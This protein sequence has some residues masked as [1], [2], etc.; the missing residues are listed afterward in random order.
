VAPSAMQDGDLDDFLA[1]AEKVGFPLLIKASAGGGGKGMKIVREAS[2]LKEQITTAASEA[3]VIF[4]IEKPVSLL[5]K[6]QA[7]PFLVP[8]SVERQEVRVTLN[9]KFL[10]KRER[11][12]IKNLVPGFLNSIPL[13]AR[14]QIFPARIWEW[15]RPSN[16]NY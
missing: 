5:L 4:E 15:I 7:A 2:E 1:K 10:T 6:I 8:G 9:G 14:T 12:K 11:L 3:Q 13:S 16:L